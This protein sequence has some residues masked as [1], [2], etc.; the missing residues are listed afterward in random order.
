MKL[1][2]RERIEAVP[3][4]VRRQLLVVLQIDGIELIAEAR[5]TSDAVRISNLI[6]RALTPGLMS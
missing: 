5:D 2:T 6:A 4:G 3:G 1:T